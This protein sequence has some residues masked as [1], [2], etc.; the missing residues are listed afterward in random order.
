MTTREQL[1]ASLNR[2]PF[3]FFAIELQSGRIIPV[4]KDTEVFSPRA[5]PTWFYV[6]T[7]DGTT[8]YF[9]LEAIQLIIE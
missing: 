3:R 8:S 1:D 4:T 2:Q 6:F 5:H 9:E 7:D